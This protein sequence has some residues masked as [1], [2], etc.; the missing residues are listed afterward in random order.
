MPVLAMSFASGV[1]V[2]LV[3]ARVAWTTNYRYIFLVWNLM[4]A[5]LPLLFALLAEEQ[6][7][8]RA[9]RT[10][11]FAGLA[12]AWLLFFPNAPY[13]F[14]DLI[15]LTGYFSTHFWVDLTSILCCAL[16]GF[17]LGF[18]S[19]FM[20]Q[21]LVRQRFGALVGWGFIAAVAGLSSFGVCL[22]RFMRFN[23][24]DILCKP[25]K[26]YHHLG[27]W[28]TDPWGQKFSLGFAGLFAAFI[29]ITY[30][31]LYALTHLD[32]ALAPLPG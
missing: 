13:I 19:L 26:L 18:V 25:L 29:F 2:L 10:W 11:R 32:R 1:C 31:M 15:H 9:G 23:S 3:A 12:A 5:W 17:M 30:L 16:T 22:G 21:G 8:V 7:Q 20:M 24:W 14:T 6:F 27:G 4:L 28:L